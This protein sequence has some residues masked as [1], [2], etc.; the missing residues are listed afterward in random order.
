MKSNFVKKLLSPSSVSCRGDEVLDEAKSNKEIK[1]E[2]L[3][4]V[5]N[6]DSIAGTSKLPTIQS[7]I[8][9][10]FTD[11]HAAAHS[12]N[13]P[14]F[15]KTASESAV[16]VPVKTKVTQCQPGMS[17][18]S[19]LERVLSVNDDGSD[20]DDSR[21]EDSQWVRCDKCVLNITDKMIIENGD[22]LT[23]KHIQMAQYLLKCQFP[24]V[25][26]LYNTLKQQKRVIGCTANTIQIIHCTRRKHWIM[27]S[28]KGCP[29]GEVNV[30]DTIFDK[31]DYE[32][33]DIIK[34]MFSVKTCSKINIVPVQKQNGSKDCGVFAIAIMT[35][36]AY[37]EDPRNVTYKQNSLRAHLLECFTKKSMHLFPQQ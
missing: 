24:L 27:V 16:E 14:N 3:A 35:S 31:L 15:E 22:E 18:V 37:S 13:K 8:E 2:A 12:E 10:S 25:G 19:V 20:S 7:S 1:K 29:A 34:R 21:I 4:Q 30:Y 36:I 23:D 9:S 32:T 26:G 28:T 5:D 33:R 6:P 17:G 11:P